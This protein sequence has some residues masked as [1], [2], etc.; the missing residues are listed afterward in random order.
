M[1]R[2][3]ALARLFLATFLGCLAPVPSASDRHVDGLFLPLSYS[4]FLFFN[5]AYC[6]SQGPMALEMIKDGGRGKQELVW[7][8]SSVTHGLDGRT[9]MTMVRE[10]G[11]SLADHL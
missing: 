1:H 7:I 8:L 11:S 10:N 2:S 6:S 5:W 3:N 4:S 9:S